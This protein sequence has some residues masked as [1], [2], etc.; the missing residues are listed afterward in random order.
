M[1]LSQAQYLV[2]ESD[3]FVKTTAELSSR[4]SKDVIVEITVS[5]GSANGIVE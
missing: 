3:N 5:D 4:A 1:S 2:E